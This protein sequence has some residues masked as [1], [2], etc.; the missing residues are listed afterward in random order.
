MQLPHRILPDAQPNPE[1]PANIK[2]LIRRFE[3]ETIR[4][5]G[6]RHVQVRFILKLKLQFA[7]Q[8]KVLNN[9]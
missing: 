3:K 2:Y 5:L 6:V 7:L 4:I 9:V 1:K 8:H